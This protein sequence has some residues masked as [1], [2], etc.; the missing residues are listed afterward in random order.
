[1][2]EPAIGALE[3]LLVPLNGLRLRFIVAFKYNPTFVR[4]ATMTI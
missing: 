2:A 3:L 4:K 1:M